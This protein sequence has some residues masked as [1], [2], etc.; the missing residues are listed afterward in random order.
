M[1][2]HA[3]LISL[4]FHT[5]RTSWGIIFLLNIRYLLHSMLGFLGTQAQCQFQTWVPSYLTRGRYVLGSGSNF[6]VEWL[7][8]SLSPPLKFP[9]PQCCREAVLML[10]HGLIENIHQRPEIE[11]PRSRILSRFSSPLEEVI[12]NFL[13]LLR[14]LNYP[15]RDHIFFQSNSE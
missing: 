8:F 3:P 13:V 9:D 14:I 11:D 15:R 1:S 2:A 5:A 12:P 10:S 6:V 7:A 4:S